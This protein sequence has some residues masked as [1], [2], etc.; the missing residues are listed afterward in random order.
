[1]NGK[2]PAPEFHN[3]SPIQRPARPSA[4]LSRV[5]K[6][7]GVKPEALGDAVKLA[8]LGLVITLVGAAVALG[9]TALLPAQYAARTQLLYRISSEQPT[10][11]LREDRTLTTQAFLL[12]SRTVVEPVAVANG[13]ST[14]E[15]TDRLQVHVVEGSLILEVEVHDTDPATALRLVQE[16][17]DRYFETIRP[18][19]QPE[20]RQYFETQLAEIQTRLRDLP[21]TAAER[22]ELAVREVDVQR[23]LD[24]VRLGAARESRA[25]VVVPPYSVGAPV[26]PRPMFALASGTLTGLLVAMAV[27]A[28]LARQR[29]RARR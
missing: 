28:M 1:V 25:E 3:G 29:N 18:S 7:L 6:Q 4:L 24:D 27:V 21:P 19:D 22:P 15:L 9:V 20:L 26:S 13:M 10:G 11:F 2:R 5:A 23:Q 16:I 12:G 14:D 8:V 17:S